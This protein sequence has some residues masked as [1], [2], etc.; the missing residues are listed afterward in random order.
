MKNKHIVTELVY[1]AIDEINLMQ[2]KD[3]KI[4]KSFGTELIGTSSAMDSLGLVNFI[5]ELEQ[6][7]Q[8]NF[9]LSINFAEQQ[10]HS[11]QQTQLKTVGG[12]IEYVCYQI[13]KKEGG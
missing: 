1:S 12:V 4:Q 13:E 6:K 10:S 9:N 8:E 2:P 7:I 11:G 3:K 5:I